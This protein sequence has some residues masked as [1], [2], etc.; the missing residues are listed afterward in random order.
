M[1]T[2]SNYKLSESVSSCADEKMQ[3]RDI[4]WG[5]I[6]ERTEREF[7]LVFLKCVSID[8]QITVR[9]VFV[10]VVADLLYM[11]PPWQ[12]WCLNSVTQTVIYSITEF[13]IFLCVSLVDRVYVESLLL[14]W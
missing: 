12:L 11:Q 1:D 8:V 5:K 13:S 14:R 2:Y 6:L 7:T 9:R 3:E 10:D 4:K